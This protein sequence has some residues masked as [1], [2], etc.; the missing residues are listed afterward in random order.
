MLAARSCEVDDTG[1]AMLQVIQ[2]AWNYFP[3]RALGGRCPAEIMMI[4]DMAAGDGSTVP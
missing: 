4:K 2:D 3:H 1:D